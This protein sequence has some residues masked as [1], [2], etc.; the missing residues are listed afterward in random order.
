MADERQR[1]VE[2]VAGLTGAPTLLEDRAQRMVAFC[3][4]GDQIDEVRRSSILRRTTAPAIIA[5][6]TQFGIHSA[7]DP[8]RTP[9]CPEK[10]I[11]G[12]LCVPLRYQGR[13]MG[14]LWFIDDARQLTDEQVATVAAAAGPI[15]LLMY[16]EELVARM[17][18]DVV[19]HLLSPSQEL[20][21]LAVQ[22]IVDAELLHGE[23]YAVA[24]VQPV[25]RG[26]DNSAAIADALWELGLGQPSRSL[27]R[28]ARRDHGAV[29]IALPDTG[30]R[31]RRRAREVAALARKILDRQME[32]AAV[33]TVAALGSP[34]NELASVAVSYH[35]AR[36]AA[37]VSSA[38][39]S[40][41]DITEWET[42][43]VFR[44]LALLPPAAV[45]TSVVD[46][47]LLS[48]IEE[49][50]EDVIRTVEAYLDHAGNAKETANALFIHRA[51]LYYRLGKAEKLAGLD[52]RDGETRLA[53]HLGFKLL[54]LIGSH[55]L[56]TDRAGTS[57][58]DLAA[59]A[60][61]IAPL[62]V[63]GG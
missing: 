36:L 53:L 8:L 21:H 2:M 34:Q 38:I 16:R 12:R 14:F 33:R 43:G 9:S 54:R 39:P 60:A 48:I 63:P 61:Q 41:G 28:L 49:G 4:H 17:E 26:P 32:A 25:D 35:Q 27:L 20:R 7:I 62:T 56:V 23:A 22:D 59:T 50:D 3:A 52:L 19:N 37:G 51:T 1:I 10:G 44:A 6:F 42:L 18:T 58:A 31:A 55:P 30:P 24:V 40:L 45:S 29:V 57:F 15:G 47:R 5:W 11:L 46:P 13:L